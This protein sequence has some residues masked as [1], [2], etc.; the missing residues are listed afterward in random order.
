[1]TRKLGIAPY[2]LTGDERFLSIRAFTEAHRLAAFERQKGVCPLCGK[3]FP[4]GEM[5]ADHIVPWSKGGRTVPENCQ[6]L[7]R[8]CNFAKGGK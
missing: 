1:V 7:C 2:V 6:M 5:H 3:A 8:A 4:L